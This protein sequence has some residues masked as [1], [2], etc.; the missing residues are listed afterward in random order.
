MCGVNPHI[1]PKMGLDV[2][3]LRKR[4]AFLSRMWYII[5]TKEKEKIKMEEVMNWAILFGKVWVIAQ[6]IGYVF[7]AIL[8][9]I[10]LVIIIKTFSG[11][12]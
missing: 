10:V 9:I 2:E 1:F 5:T 4:L 11:R 6:I 12:Y 3:R 7:A 8:T